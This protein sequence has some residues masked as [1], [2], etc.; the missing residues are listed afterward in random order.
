MGLTRKHRNG[1]GLFGNNASKLRSQLATVNKYKTVQA[2][3][4]QLNTNIQTIKAAYDAEKKIYTKSKA[5]VWDLWSKLQTLKAKKLSYA[6]RY[7]FNSTASLN[8][9]VEAQIQKLNTRKAQL[10]KKQAELANLLKQNNL[11][12]TLGPVPP[13]ALNALPV[14]DPQVNAAAL[15]ARKARIA[16]KKAAARARAAAAQGSY[17]ST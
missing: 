4:K 10:R 12:A 15:A 17:Q 9:K 2:S 3:S 1:G 14:P 6:P 16:A 7:G 13:T 11:P 5:R 8:K